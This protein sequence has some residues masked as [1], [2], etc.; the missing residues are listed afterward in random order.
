[1]VRW[2]YFGMVRLGSA[3][4]NRNGLDCACKRLIARRF[5]IWIESRVRCSEFTVYGRGGVPSE[6]LQ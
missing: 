2:E 1:M 5:V 6:T 3:W 4:G